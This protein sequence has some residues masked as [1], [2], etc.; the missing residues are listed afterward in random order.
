MNRLVTSALF[1]IYFSLPAF[2]QFKL[3]IVISGIKNTKGNLMLQLLDE[4]EK[5]LKQEMSAISDTILTITFADLAPGKYAIRYYHDEN[6]NG[7][8]DTNFVGKPTEGYG[9]SNNVIGKKGPPEFEKW[10]FEINGDKKLV[11]KPTY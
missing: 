10:L 7:K 3:E 8:M 2:S 6:V 9:F 5:V 4:K 1:I 11:L